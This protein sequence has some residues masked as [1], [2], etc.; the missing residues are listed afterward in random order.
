MWVSLVMAREE[1]WARDLEGAELLVM[2]FLPPT[3][4]VAEE[5]VAD[6]ASK[7]HRTNQYF[8]GSK[9]QH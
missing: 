7:F 4:W 2:H 5:Q 6:H 8:E 1:G 3:F 9:L